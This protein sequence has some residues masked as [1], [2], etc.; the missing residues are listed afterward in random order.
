[1]TPITFPS[2]RMG[3]LSIFWMDSGSSE[4]IFTPSKTAAC[5]ATMKLLSISG[6]L[7]RAV[8]AARAEL[9]ERGMNP[10]FFRASGTR[11]WRWRQRV[12]TPMMATSSFRTES[13]LAIFSAT[14][15]RE[16]CDA[17]P[18]SALKA[19]AMRSS[20]VTRPEVALIGSLFSCW[21]CGQQWFGPADPIRHYSIF[22][23]VC[24]AQQE[25]SELFVPAERTV[26]LASPQTTAY[27]DFAAIS[28]HSSGFARRKPVRTYAAER[29]CPQR[30]PSLIPVTSSESFI[31]LPV[32]FPSGRSWRNISGRTAPRW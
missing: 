14:E 2:E 17:L 23:R 31:P 24:A 21:I 16:N 11:K 6:R 1:M 13:V 22:V 29:A 4:L 3:A 28:Q 26:Q 7:S 32:Y 12:E 15:V 19:V 20:S 8:R 9:L 25:D 27:T 18:S 5:R 30:K 10:T